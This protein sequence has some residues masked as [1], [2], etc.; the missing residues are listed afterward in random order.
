MTNHEGLTLLLTISENK[1]ALS[2]IKNYLHIFSFLFDITVQQKRLRFL[3][4][5]YN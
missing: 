4:K 5:N 2:P 1:I 3:F